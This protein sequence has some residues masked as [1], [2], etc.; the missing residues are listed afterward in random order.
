MKER[1]RHYF[2]EDPQKSKDFPRIVTMQKTQRLAAFLQNGNVIAGGEVDVRERYIS[3]TILDGIRPDHP[4]MQEEI[5]GPILPVMEF[6]EIKEVVDYVNSQPKPLAFYYFSQDSARQE[7]I[8]MRTTSGGGCINEVVTHIANENLP[9]GGVGNSGIGRYHGK[10][11]FETFSNP[12]SILKKA[13]W[14][15]I[16]LRYP[17]YRLK[18]KLVRMIMK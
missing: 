15:D 3:P 16:P 18:H 13:T 6:G 5:F 1:I 11:S 12:R 7:D 9:Y 4:I 14:I 2:G 10:Y 17:P 8:L